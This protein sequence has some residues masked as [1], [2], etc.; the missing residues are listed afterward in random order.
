MERGS[1]SSTARTWTRLGEGI[2]HDGRISADAISR[3]AATIAAM[4]AEAKTQGAQA[5]AAVGVQQGL[6]LGRGPLVVFDTGG[7]SSSSSW[8]SCGRIASR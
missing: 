5:I 4:V 6:D 8:R 2:E 3:T 7:G 1:P